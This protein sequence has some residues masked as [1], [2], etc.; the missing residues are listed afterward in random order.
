MR[1]IE[2]LN[3]S[4]DEVSLLCLFRQLT[5][6]QQLMILEAA[7]DCVTRNDRIEQLAGSGVERGFDVEFKGLM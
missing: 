1:K 5:T 6:D 3:L 2:C 7:E 4:R